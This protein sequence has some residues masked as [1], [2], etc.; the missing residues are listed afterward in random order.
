MT[1]RVGTAGWSIASRFTAAFPSEGSALSR[2]AAVLPAVEINSSFYRPHRPETYARWAQ[3]VPE[4]FR[5]AVKVPRIITHERR[6]L[7]PEEPLDRFLSEVL[8]LG[9]RLGPILI[10]LPPSLAFETETAERF[11]CLVRE[12]FAG[13]LVIEPRHPGWFSAE[14]EALLQRWRIHRV[15]ADPAIVPAARRPGGA[16]GFVYLRLHGSPRIYHSPYG[17]H[18]LPGIAEELMAAVGS[19]SWCIFD[20]T[21]S[22]AALADALALS[23]LV[24]PSV[25]RRS[26]G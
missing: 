5:F 10:Q 23:S 16:P 18:L 4:K 6:L 17:R 12:R 8:V 2:Y 26:R 11:L 14:A 7:D 21:A 24:A 1:I 3:S 20:N 19:E 9:D 13:T 25:R 15:A 22:S